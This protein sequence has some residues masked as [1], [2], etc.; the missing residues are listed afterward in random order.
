MHI[1]TNLWNNFDKE[2]KG[3]NSKHHFVRFQEEP[4]DNIDKI[5]LLNSNR[6]QT[7]QKGITDTEEQNYWKL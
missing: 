2:T 7:G 3:G 5:E 6:E 1:D 4:S